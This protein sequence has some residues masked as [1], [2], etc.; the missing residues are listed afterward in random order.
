[1][2]VWHRTRPEQWW[3]VFYMLEFWF[4]AGF[5]AALVWSLLADRR[6]FARM[7]AEAARERENRSRP[8]T[9]FSETP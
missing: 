6:T 8:A 5:A 7:D 4:S 1:M 2:A 3:G 9:P